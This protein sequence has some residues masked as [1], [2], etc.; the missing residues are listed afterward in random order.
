MHY[1]GGCIHP[2]AVGQ[3]DSFSVPFHFFC[4]NSQSLSYL[5]KHPML[6]LL[7]LIN[8]PPPAFYLILKDKGG[9][10]PILLGREH[11]FNSDQQLAFSRAD[12]E[13]GTHAGSLESSLDHGRGC[14]FHLLPPPSS[15]P[16]P[17]PSLFPSSHS[18]FQY[19]PT[20]QC[21]ESGYGKEWATLA[22]LPSLQG[23][24]QAWTTTHTS[25]LSCW[26]PQ[27]HHTN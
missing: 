4:T 25:W 8:S 18:K 22:P 12:E 23:A 27:L 26:N 21:T 1:R 7:T 20:Q 15:P 6:H 9:K 16:S 2:K 13:R 5:D 11:R 3:C 17:I 24:I 14:T 10:Q 19:H